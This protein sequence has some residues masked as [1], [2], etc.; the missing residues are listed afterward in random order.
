MNA[1]GPL[2]A[3]SVVAVTLPLAC[4]SKPN[5]NANFSVGTGANDGGAPTNCAPGQPCTQPA[6]QC[7]PGQPCPAQSA[8]SSS[9]PAGGDPNGIAA[10]LAAAAAA[11]SAWMGPGGVTGD[12][13][14]LGLRAAAAQHAAGMTPEKD[15]AKGQLAEG[16]HLG[17]IVNMDAAHCYA[18][19]AFG[20]GVA[21]LDVNLL[22]P[23]LYN[24]LAGSDGMAGPTA[25]VGGGGKPICPIVPLAVPYK[26]DLYAKKGG[27]SVAA[28]VYSKPK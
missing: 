12:P 18:I 15:I 13:A 3:L 7:Q 16:Q 4:G 2:F 22:A 9:A 11:G 5:A 25:V 19:V 10:L 21:D 14:E 27:G 28:Q 8:P 23:P 24:M 20:A 26:V 1:R 6:G 17:F